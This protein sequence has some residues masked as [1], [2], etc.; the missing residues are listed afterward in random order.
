MCDGS[1]LAKSTV[2]ALGNSRRLALTLLRVARFRARAFGTAV[3]VPGPP[4]VGTYHLAT[5]AATR[6]TRGRDV[7]IH[8]RRRP[9]HQTNK[10]VDQ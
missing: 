2:D 9:P 5:S 8:G 3:G 4:I 7:A 10:E 6:R 1:F